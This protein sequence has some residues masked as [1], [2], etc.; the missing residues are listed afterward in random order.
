MTGESGVTP[1][2]LAQLAD[3]AAP[4]TEA[5]REAVALMAEVRGLAE[6][7]PD[8][9][10]ERVRAIAA[11]GAAEPHGW[12]RWLATGDGRRRLAIAGGPVVAV[13]V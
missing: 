13:I 3:G 1:E 7:A 9:V 8:A 12:R 11:S 2:R 5:E 4:E 6:P 10:R